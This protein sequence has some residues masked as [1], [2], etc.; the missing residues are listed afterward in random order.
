MLI[1]KNGISVVEHSVLTGKVLRVSRRPNA[2]LSVFDLKEKDYVYVEDTGDR[3]LY[4]WK[5]QFPVQIQWENTK[6]VKVYEPGT[7]L[8]V[9]TKKA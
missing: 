1:N 3:L 8:H 5:D 2:R 4:K 9:V 6:A 7:V